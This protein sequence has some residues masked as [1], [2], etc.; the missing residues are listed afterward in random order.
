MAYS[1]EGV[2]L[3]FNP[4][5]GGAAPRVF[6]Y[7]DAAAESDATL[8]GAGF[9]ATGVT[10]GMRKGDIVEVVQT[11]TPKLKRYQVLSVSGAAA[12]V[13]APTAIT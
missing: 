5:G 2:M 7:Y 1:A 13:Q 9:F 11:A 8:V 4:V 3:L 6:V 10:L 12:T